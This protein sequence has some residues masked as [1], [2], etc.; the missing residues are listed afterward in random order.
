MAFLTPV[1]MDGP[2]T[3]AQLVRA[4]FGSLISSAGGTIAAGGLACAQKGTPNMSVIVAGGTAAEGAAWLPGTT[5]SSQGSY[6]CW[7]SAN[8]EQAIA[9]SG[10]TNPRVDTVIARVYDNSV[11]SSGKTEWTTEIVKGA[12]ETGCTLANLKGI[13]A[14]PASSLVLAYVLVPAKATS[15]LTA[16]IANVAT[17]YNLGFDSGWVEPALLHSWKNAGGEYETMAYRK[18]GNTVRL[19]G[20]ITGGVSVTELF[21]LPAGYRPTGRI[22]LIAFGSEGS[23]YCEVYATGIVVIGWP[24]A[25]ATVDLSGLTFTID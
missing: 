24:G 17:V 23:A 2:S 7:N 20:A 16:D 3:D 4:A 14:V 19:R 5:T 9:A 8:Y 25:S 18:Q 11:D 6:F 10:A 21:T 13:G 22:K 1:A 15:I 12:E